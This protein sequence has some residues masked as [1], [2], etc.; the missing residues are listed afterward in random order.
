MREEKYIEKKRE[1]REEIG[2]RRM[3]LSP[4]GEALTSIGSR[5]LTRTLG[6]TPSVG[7]NLQATPRRVT[8]TPPDMDREDL[9]LSIITSFPGSPGVDS[10]DRH[11]FLHLG[12][13]LDI[14]LRV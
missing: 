9:T 5:L 13:T 3:G 7:C 10:A 12:F 2:E 8:S 6:P 11:A 4:I 14:L 1:K